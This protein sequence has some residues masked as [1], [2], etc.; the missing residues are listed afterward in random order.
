MWFFL[1]RKICSTFEK[2]LEK[3]Q[4]KS[5]SK[6]KKKKLRNLYIKNP[7][8]V[9]RQNSP[10]LTLFPPFSKNANFRNFFSLFSVNKK[11]F[12][13]NI[14]F[15]FFAEKNFRIFP[16]LTKKVL[17]LKIAPKYPNREWIL[18]HGEFSTLISGH[19]DKNDSSIFQKS[20][21]NHPFRV[22]FWNFLDVGL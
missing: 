15:P 5:T 8:P 10:N 21:K 19:N 4:I 17:F 16:F 3:V 9:H 20:V 2:L 7:I 1:Q 22:F 13:S 6:M 18:N 11:H 14:Y 12:C